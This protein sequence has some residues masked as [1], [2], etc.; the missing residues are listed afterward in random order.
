MCG[1]SVFVNTEVIPK[2]LS[3]RLFKKSNRE[4]NSLCRKMDASILTRSSNA[5]AISF[6]FNVTE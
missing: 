1:V 6:E 4:E 5:N 3:L 2:V